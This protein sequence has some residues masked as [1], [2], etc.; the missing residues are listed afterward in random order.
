MN[1]PW[2]EINLEHYEKHMSLDSVGQ[3]QAL[4]A[5]MKEQF[6]SWPAHTAMVLGIA[7]GNG[8][9]HV[10]KEKYRT[11]WGVDINEGWLRTAAERYPGL[12]GVLQCLCLDLSKDAEKLPKAASNPETPR[13]RAAAASARHSR[14]GSSRI[15]MPSSAMGMANRI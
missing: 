12:Q 11:V 4:N 14:V 8:L 1:H 13:L 6:D 3:L 2:E 15:P 5:L 9:E 7:G 10:R